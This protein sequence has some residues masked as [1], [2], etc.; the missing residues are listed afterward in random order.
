[1]KRAAGGTNVAWRWKSF[2]HSLTPLRLFDREKSHAVS[3]ALSPV[4]DP[5]LSIVSS[6]IRETICPLIHT[7]FLSSI[8]CQRLIC[9]VFLDADF[10]AHICILLLKWSVQSEGLQ[11]K[12][13]KQ[14][15]FNHNIKTNTIVHRPHGLFIWAL[16]F[17]SSSAALFLYLIWPALCSLWSD[18][19]ISSIKS[20]LSTKLKNITLHYN[21]WCSF[22]G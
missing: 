20:T 18:S 7:A 17:T 21:Y 15:L 12:A 16:R 3:K 9:S 4:S 5:T 10:T 2:T 1:M 22:W 19:R 13:T 6:H 14:L 8:I 11:A